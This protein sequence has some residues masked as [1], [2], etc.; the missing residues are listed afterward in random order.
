MADSFGFAQCLPVFRI[1]APASWETAQS[2]GSQV[3]VTL[4]LVTACLECKRLSKQ[5][6]E[7][8][9]KWPL[10]TSGVR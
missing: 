1:E 7:C 10:M 8:Q 4:G 5:R 2:L 3:V 9:G 6:N